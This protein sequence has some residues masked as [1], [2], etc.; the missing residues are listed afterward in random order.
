LLTYTVNGETCPARR[1]RA[2]LHRRLHTGDLGPSVNVLERVHI[3]YCRER[4][5]AHKCPRIFQFRSE[6]PKNTLGRVLTDELAR[7]YGALS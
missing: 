4:L 3:G 7:A 6:L 2:A 5:A 1:S